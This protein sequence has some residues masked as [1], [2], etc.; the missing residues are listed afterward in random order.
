MACIFPVR[1]TPD[2]CRAR[3]DLPRSYPLVAP[4]YAK[5]QSA[6][7]LVCQASGVKNCSR[8]QVLPRR[9]PQEIEQG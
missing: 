2:E 7:S 6:L 1:G 4:G 9:G 5:T 8:S 3:Y